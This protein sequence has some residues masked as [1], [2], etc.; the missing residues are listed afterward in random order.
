MLPPVSEWPSLFLRICL[1]ATL[2]LCVRGIVW[3]V[4]MLLVRP[5]F[6]PFKHLPGPDGSLFTS[7]LRDVMDPSYSTRTYENWRQVFGQTIRFHGFGRHD[8]RLLSFDTS[9]IN[10]V[11]YSPKYEKPW[12]TR[13]FLGRLI[14]EGIFSVEGAQHTLQ[15][16]IVA[17]AFR[18]PRIKNM[19]P[20]FFR[21]AEELTDRWKALL[22]HQSSKESCD[23]IV[24]VSHWISRATFDVIGLA[25]FNY[26]FHSVEDES[27]P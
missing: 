9:V 3:L 21:K 13:S 14:G 18:P 27:E 5:F 6:D 12:Q 4:N 8:Y 23:S 2:L 24:D 10:H 20:I 17:P 16:R 7:H 15:T 25:G 26:N 22:D 1:V 19:V 11:M